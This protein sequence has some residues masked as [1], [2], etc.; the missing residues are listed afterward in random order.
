VGDRS[1]ADI[2]EI[3]DTELTRRQTGRNG[4]RRE[5]R[6]QRQA[7][8]N[9]GAKKTK[10]GERGGEGWGARNTKWGRKARKKRS[11]KTE[12]KGGVQ[13]GGKK[14]GTMKVVG[15]RHGV[16]RREDA[17]DNTGV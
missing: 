14:R 11:K 4:G 10:G 15:G 16:R 8:K 13:G 17:R 5:G 1:A 6:G 2:I 12:R 9:E 7:R 3:G